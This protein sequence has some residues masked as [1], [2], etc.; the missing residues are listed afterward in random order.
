MDTACKHH[1]ALEP[2]GYDKGSLGT[3]IGTKDAIRFKYFYLLNWVRGTWTFIL[4]LM[5]V[6]KSIHNYAHMYPF[7]FFFVS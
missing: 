7:S 6:S 3:V 5:Y 2:H 4:F 1:C